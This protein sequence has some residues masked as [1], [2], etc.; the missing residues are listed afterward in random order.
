MGILPHEE[1]SPEAGC[2]E[3]AYTGSRMVS[4]VT[5]GT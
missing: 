3:Q 4:K 5:Y 2:I 1:V